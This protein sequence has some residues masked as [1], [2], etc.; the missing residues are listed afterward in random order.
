M[1]TPHLG[2]LASRTVKNKFLW[3]ILERDR[4]TMKTSMKRQVTGTGHQKKKG[5]CDG[6]TFA[7]LKEVSAMNGSH[8]SHR[9]TYTG[10]LFI[11]IIGK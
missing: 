3:F 1:L 4:E 11:M 6:E 9:V 2:L 5:I 8:N 10:F 7:N